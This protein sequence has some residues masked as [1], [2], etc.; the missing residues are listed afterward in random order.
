[1]P[2][3]IVL[4][5]SKY[6]EAII[7][8]RPYRDDVYA[9]LEKEIDKREG[10][11]ISKI[12]EHKFGIDLYIS[13]QKFARRLG[14]TMRKKYRKAEIKITR[15]LH[16]QDRLTSKKLYR[17]TVLIRYPLDEEDKS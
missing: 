7:Q 14:A 12:V 3:S 13:S 4:A 17:A 5:P 6:F 16:T 10:V 9:F 8:L 1:M 2:K 11:F 15:K